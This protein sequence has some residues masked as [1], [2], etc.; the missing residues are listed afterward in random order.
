MAKLVIEDVAHDLC[1]AFHSM[2]ADD[3]R[4]AVEALS[5]AVKRL[6]VQRR[7]AGGIDELHRTMRE[8]RE[9]G[10]LKPI[11]KEIMEEALGGSLL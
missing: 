7:S 2:S 8:L 9:A 4:V 5:S 6:T 11:T 10:V 1:C 3:R